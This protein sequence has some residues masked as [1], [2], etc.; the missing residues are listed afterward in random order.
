MGLT[1]SQGRKR[2]LEARKKVLMV[3]FDADKFNLSK[4]EQDK[5]VDICNQLDSLSRKLK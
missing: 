3:F 1:K 2:L 4:R 5:M